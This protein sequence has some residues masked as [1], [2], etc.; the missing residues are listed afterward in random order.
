[1]CVRKCISVCHSDRQGGLYDM[2]MFIYVSV[3]IQM[4]TDDEI[5]NHGYV[6]L[7][8]ILA[9]KYMAFRS[10]IGTWRVDN[11]AVLILTRNKY[12]QCLAEEDMSNASHEDD[13][14]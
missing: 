3:Y 8:L 2:R 6:L 14:E 11:K 10:L 12:R 4:C 13:V 5:R 7:L 9:D 1:M